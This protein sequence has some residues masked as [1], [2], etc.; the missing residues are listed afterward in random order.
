MW[1]TVETDS[2]GPEIDILADDINLLTH[3]KAQRVLG[4]RIDVNCPKWL[5]QK[6]K[7]FLEGVYPGVHITI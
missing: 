1:L 3:K 4:N 2:N 6:I 7:E 5:L